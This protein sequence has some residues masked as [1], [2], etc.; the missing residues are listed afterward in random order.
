MNN[1][2]E[3]LLAYKVKTMEIIEFLRKEDYDN[4][5]KSVKERQLII[6]A[7]EKLNYNNIEFKGLASELNLLTMEEEVNKKTKEK[8]EGIKNELMDVKKY[9][10]G[11]K[12]YNKNKYEDFKKIDKKV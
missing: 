4:V 1:L 5:Q 8:F 11:N 7:I 2:K 6:D 10:K 3:L 9:Y 12:K